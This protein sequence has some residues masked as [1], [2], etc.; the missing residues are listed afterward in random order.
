MQEHAIS[1]LAAA[2]HGLITLGQARSAGLSEAAVKRRLA[3][4]RWLRIHGAVYGVAGAPRT[5]QQELL[6][7][8]LA[9]GGIVAASHRSAA[10]LLG[11]LD[12]DAGLVD[13][14]VTR[15]QAPVPSGVVVHRIADLSHR[16][17]TVVDGI[18]CTVV[19]RTLVD[20]G[21][22]ARLGIVARAL[23]RA[24][25][26]RLTT[27]TDVRSALDSVARKG[28]AGAG[29]IRR[30]LDE[31]T[32]A[33]RP[34]GVLEARMAAL[35]RAHDVP[36]ALPEYRVSARGVFVGRVDFAYPELKLAIE[37]DGFE[38][39][40]A[41]DVFRKD[42]ARQNDLVSNGWTVLRYVWRDVNAMAWHVAWEIER[43]RRRL[44]AEAAP[45]LG[46]EKIA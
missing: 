12:D 7:A 13:I 25:G 35:L 14:T 40:T 31:R 4:G 8:V 43:T 2:Q 29:A 34:A 46:S 17:I 33:P 9:A 16:W 19:E 39:H 1:D 22:V 32:D 3:S 20:F 26:R 10:R 23:D 44:A 45:V 28:R 11:L 36:R 27:V 6:A 15:P 41:L 5:T 24:I 30:L 37:V 38:P 21:A 18:P 42:R